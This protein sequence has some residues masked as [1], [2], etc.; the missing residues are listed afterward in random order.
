M[1]VDLALLQLALQ[2]G[3]VALHH[4]RHVRVGDR[5]NGALVLVHLRQHLGGDRDR[6]AGHHLVGNL[7]NAL[8]VMAAGVGVHQADGQRLDPPRLEVAELLTQVVLFQLAHGLAAR[9]GALVRLDGELQRRQRLGLG[10]YDPAG[11][12]A[13]HEGAG[14][15]K[16]LPVALRGHDADARALAFQDG[17]GGDRRAV[18]HVGDLGRLDAGVVAYPLDAVEHAD[19]GVVRG[20]GH[21][22]AEG[23]AA[24]LVDQQQIGER[25]ADVDA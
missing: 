24:R 23:A 20:G 21:L 2:V 18:H 8:L 14:D 7:P 4:R 1:G 9:A 15:L 11:E 25:A 12:D 10:P 19:R 22:R 3:D 13:G 16:H 5:G 17:V 6:H